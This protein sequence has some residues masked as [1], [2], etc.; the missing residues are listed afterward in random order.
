MKKV[1]LIMTTALLFVSISCNCQWYQRQYGVNDINQLSQE[2]LNEALLNAQSGRAVGCVMLTVGVIGSVGSWLVG[3]TIPISFFGGTT[4]ENR[5]RLNR[6][7]LIGCCSIPVG[8]TGGVILGKYNTRVRTIKGIMNN[9]EIK[10]G[11]LNYSA[12]NKPGSSN[13]SSIP[14]FSITFNF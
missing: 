9:T 2:Q 5:S 12:S 10:L 14:G 13:Y 7:I 1:F 4:V 8:I 3:R 11:L 6:C